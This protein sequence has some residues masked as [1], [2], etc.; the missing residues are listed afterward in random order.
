MGGGW[1]GGGARA[2]MGATAMNVATLCYFTLLL[3][4]K[5]ALHQTK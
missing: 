1:G 3:P 4:L 5:V 2:H